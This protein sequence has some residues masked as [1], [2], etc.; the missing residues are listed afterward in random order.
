MFGQ[1]KLST[2]YISFQ[3]LKIPNNFIDLKASNKVVWGCKKN[4][5]PQQDMFLF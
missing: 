3:R 1:T 2:S 4:G 5:E